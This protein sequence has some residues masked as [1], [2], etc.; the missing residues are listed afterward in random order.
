MIQ[1]FTYLSTSMT[2][3]QAMQRKLVLLMGSKQPPYDLSLTIRDS[4]SVVD[5]FRRFAMLS[6]TGSAVLGKLGD[7]FLISG[8]FGDLGENGSIWEFWGF[9]M[10]SG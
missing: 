4:I 7:F 2:M 8:N 3:L 5:C 9:R 1:D 6:V 10:A